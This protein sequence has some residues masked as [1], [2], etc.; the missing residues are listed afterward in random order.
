MLLFH[1]TG[2]FATEEIDISVRVVLS[3]DFYLLCLMSWRAVSIDTTNKPTGRQPIIISVVQHL[4]G[5][6]TNKN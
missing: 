6:G 1:I 2:S 3:L 5:T 4:P